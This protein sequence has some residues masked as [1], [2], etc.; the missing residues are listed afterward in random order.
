M[1]EE[2][3]VGPA[4]RNHHRQTAAGEH[5]GVERPAREWADPVRALQDDEVAQTRLGGQHGLEVADPPREHGADA[6]V[7]GIA[8]HEDAHRVSGAPGLQ[9]RLGR[10]EGLARVGLELGQRRVHGDG[11]ASQRGQHLGRV[12]AEEND[13]DMRLAIMREPERRI[14]ARA[15]VDLGA[16]RNEN[17]SYRHRRLSKARPRGT[18]RRRTTCLGRRACRYRTNG[19]RHLEPR[20]GGRRNPSPARTAARATPIGRVGMRAPSCATTMIVA[21]CPPRDL[22]PRAALVAPRCKGVDA[23]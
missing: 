8:G 18:R 22:D 10:R 1:I 21:A 11:E 16:G 6:A 3:A 7:P 20:R 13:V 15:D 23:R 5:G 14:E 9:G 2:M 12:R 17:G 4:R 19:G